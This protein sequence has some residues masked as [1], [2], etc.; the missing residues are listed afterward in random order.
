MCIWIIVIIVAFLIGVI[1]VL[2]DDLYSEESIVIP[3]FLSLFSGFV[4]FIIALFAGGIL[5]LSNSAYEYTTTAFGL[6]PLV[7]S[8]QEE[9]Y[10]YNSVSNSYEVSYNFTMDTYNGYVTKSVPAD[11]AII[12]KIE[13]GSSPRV[14]LNVPSYKSPT[15]RKS[16]FNFKQA[17]YTIYIPAESYYWTD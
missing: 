11:Q 5:S 8:N 2:K 1:Y 9:I 3:L 4:Y 14:E 16:I 17:Y 6:A 15:L 10:V 13:D 12:V 7:N